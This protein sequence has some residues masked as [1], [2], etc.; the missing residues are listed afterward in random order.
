ML[1]EI[2]LALDVIISG[3]GE[4]SLYRRAEQRQFERGGLFG[5]AQHFS[6][7]R[8]NGTYKEHYVS[9]SSTQIP[10]DRGV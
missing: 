9:D 10:L 4:A 2:E 8:L 1:V 5:G 7:S 3:A 6:R